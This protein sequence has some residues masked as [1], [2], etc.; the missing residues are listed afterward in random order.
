MRRLTELRKQKGW[1]LEELGKRSGVSREAIR[2]Y[3]AEQRVPGIDVAYAVA[4]ALGVSVEEIWPPE[5]MERPI[6]STQT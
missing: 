2:L 5:T 6:S 4:S 3:E 1:T